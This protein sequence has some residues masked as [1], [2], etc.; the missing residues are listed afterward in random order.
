MSLDGLDRYGRV[1]T[2]EALSTTVLYEHS[3]T[4]LL[5]LEMRCHPTNLYQLRETPREGGTSRP[6]PRVMFVGR[7]KGRGGCGGT[8]EEAE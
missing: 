5:S 4:A 7:A 6:I 2:C 1:V 3:L 8:E